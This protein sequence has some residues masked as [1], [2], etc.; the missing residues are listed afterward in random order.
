MLLDD[1]MG[2]KL[3]AFAFVG[4][5]IGVYWINRVLRIEV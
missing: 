1:P 4:M 2:L 3:I 5:I